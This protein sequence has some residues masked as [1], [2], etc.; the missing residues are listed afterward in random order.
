MK[1]LLLIVVF[2][3][4]GCDG[5]QNLA[6]DP[7]TN[8]HG[9]TSTFVGAGVVHG[10]LKEHRQAKIVSITSAQGADGNGFIIVY[11]NKSPNVE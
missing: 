8:M 2:V 6:T 3:L 11:E 9:Q 4:A 5:P 7:V 1:K 10:W